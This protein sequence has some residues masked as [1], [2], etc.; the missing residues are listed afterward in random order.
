[1]STLPKTYQLKYAFDLV[2]VIHLV[3]TSNTIPMVNAVAEMIDLKN[4]HS[5][6]KTSVDLTV[7][8]LTRDQTQ[9][10]FSK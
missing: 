4:H 7:K 1:M 10:L 3:A 8:D 2:D 9:N 6:K 5:I